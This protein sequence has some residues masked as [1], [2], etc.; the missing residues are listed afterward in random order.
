MQTES[1]KNR[2]TSTLTDPIM[3]VFN[4]LKFIVKIGGS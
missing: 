4:S 2:H 3:R 1:K